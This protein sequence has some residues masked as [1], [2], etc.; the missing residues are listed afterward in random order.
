MNLLSPLLTWGT[1]EQVYVHYGKIW[2]PVFL[3][4]TL[5]AMVVSRS[6]RPRGFEKWAWRA[7]IAVYCSATLSVF[8]DYWT[9]WTGDYEG[10]GVEAMLFEIGSIVMFA[11]LGLMLVTTTALGITLLAK[12]F[13]PRLPA[14]LLTLFFPLMLA[15]TSVTS[16]GSGALPIMF[17]F[18]LLGRQIAGSSDGGSPLAAPISSAAARA[19]I[20]A[21]GCRM[22]VSGG[23]LNLTIGVSSKLISDR[24]CGTD[25]PRSRP[26]SSAASAIWS[27]LATIAV[28]ACGRSSNCAVAV[29]PD[30]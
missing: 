19:A 7:A 4:F 6:R 5:C 10:D 20:A 14:V 25:R 28:G 21:I 1:P 18:G 11:S 8:L 9:Q 29:L 27:L 13:R 17:A 23:V 16:L 22:A 15:I 3:A 24:S 30:A 12:G 26:A 2:F